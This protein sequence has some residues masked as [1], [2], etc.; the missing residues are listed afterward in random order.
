MCDM[1]QN[2]LHLSAQ[3]NQRAVNIQLAALVHN[4]LQLRDYVLGQYT[5]VGSTRVI[6]RGTDFASPKVFGPLPES[7]RA[8]L[9]S[10]RSDKHICSRKG[11]KRSGASPSYLYKRSGPS[12]PAKSPSPS[13][14]APRSAL[15]RQPQAARRGTRGNRGRRRPRALPKKGG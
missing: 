9:T 14:S 15:F 5:V 8:L 3:A 13:T 7:L 4:K 11:G 10:H 12:F 6:L 1:F 2:V